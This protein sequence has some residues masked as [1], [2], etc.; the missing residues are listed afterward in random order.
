MTNDDA[1]TPPSQRVPD[2]LVMPFANVRHLGFRDKVGA[3]RLAG[4][5]QLSLR[6]F[7]NVRALACV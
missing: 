5:G 3:T 2:P 6:P 4:F 7:R 1:T